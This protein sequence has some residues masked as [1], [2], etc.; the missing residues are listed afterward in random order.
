[1][2]TSGVTTSDTAYVF[3][4]DYV[5]GCLYD[6]DA[7]MTDF[8]LEAADQTPLEARKRYIST[9]YTFAKGAIGDPSENFV[10][11]VMSANEPADDN[12]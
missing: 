12:T 8:Q 4:P 1:M 5:L 9:W 6:K 10:L 11:F 7:L 2:I 3:N